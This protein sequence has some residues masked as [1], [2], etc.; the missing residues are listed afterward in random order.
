[1]KARRTAFVL[2]ICL[3]ALGAFAAGRSSADDLTWHTGT[4]MLGGGERSPKFTV[5]SPSERWTY[6][7]VGGV[8]HWIDASGASHSGGWPECLLPPTEEHPDRDQ[9]VR[10]RFGTV[11]VDKGP[12]G[13]G[14]VVV[15]VD[16]R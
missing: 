7:A 8:A 16:C 5:V 3:A 15:S 11:S 12:F 14:P 1:M 9:L 2:L 13:S 6:G 10:V 4:A